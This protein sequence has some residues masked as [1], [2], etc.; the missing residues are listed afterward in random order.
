[1]AAAIIPMKWPDADLY[2]GS[3]E[4]CACCGKPLKGKR[5]WVEVIDGGA[6]VA[7]PG[8]NPDPNDPGYMAFYPVGLS[9]AR[10]H[11]PGFTHPD[12]L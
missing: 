11:F 8:L 12:F 1:M 6:S 4:H 5:R 9:C 3:L 7:A 10:K 2:N